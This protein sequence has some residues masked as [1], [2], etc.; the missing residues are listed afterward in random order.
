MGLTYKGLRF[1]QARLREL[2]EEFKHKPD[3]CYSYGSYALQILTQLLKEGHVSPVIID[4]N[5]KAKLREAYSGGRNEFIADPCKN[6]KLYSFDF[7]KMY[8]NCFK[9][10]YL[11]GVIKRIETKQIQYPGFYYIK[12][13]S[14]THKF[15]VLFLKNQ[16]NGQN[17]FCNGIGKG[18]F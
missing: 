6:A 3:Y 15:P 4:N 8:F 5:I 12:Y 14:Y 13:E 2:N 18:L 10:N 7:N 16:L 9:T 17:Y 11:G 1:K